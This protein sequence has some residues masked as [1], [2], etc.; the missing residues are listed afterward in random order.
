[1]TTQVLLPREVDF[2]K[3]SFGL[4]KTIPGVP[5]QNC[6]FTYEGKA[7]NLQVSQIQ[8]PFGLS[9]PDVQFNK[10]QDKFSLDLALDL[11]NPKIVELKKV[12]D[13]IDEAALNHV[14]DHIQEI[15]G[16]QSS[17]DEVKKFKLYSEFYQFK[18]DKV[19]K[20]RVV[21]DYPDRLKVKIPYDNKKTQQ[22]R[23][24]AYD[25]TGNEIKLWTENPGQENVPE[26]E[27]VGKLNKEWILKEND[28]DM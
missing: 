9:V 5:A 21:S 28:Y 2:S 19:T 25:T 6:P 13:K 1:M 24:K 3:F 20:A 10:E 14:A 11:K 26:K 4:K 18:K 23:F 12:L 27:R 7:F 17:I 8:V 22:P 16:T 15:F